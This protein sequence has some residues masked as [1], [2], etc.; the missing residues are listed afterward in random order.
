MKHVLALTAPPQCAREVRIS[1]GV[2]GG[3]DLDGG[4]QVVAAP[5]FRDDR[6]INLPGGDV[7]VG[8]GG[9]AGEAFI[10]AQVQV[11]LRAVVRHIDLAVLK[12]A[13]RAG[14]NVDIGIAFLHGD[15]QPAGLQQRADGRRGD[16]FAQRGNDA[17]GG[18]YELAHG[19]SPVAKEWKANL[20][21]EV[22]PIINTCQDT[23]QGKSGAGK[24]WNRCEKTT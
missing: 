1:L 12:R 15:L 13:H 19:V 17:A 3:D 7:A 10:M 21:F 11:R 23:P 6:V 16:A 24:G 22:K 9:H 5:F 20:F 18:E 8:A 2:A 4:A 14:V